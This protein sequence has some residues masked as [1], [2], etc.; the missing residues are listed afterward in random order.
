MLGHLG[1]RELYQTIR[2]E[3]YWTDIAL[4]TYL[5][6]RN[7]VARS[8]ER[9]CAHNRSTTLKLFPATAPLE[10]VVAQGAKQSEYGVKIKTHI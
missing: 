2:R 4:D 1:D 10:D 3:Y 7:C 8:I 9:V 5:E 6:V